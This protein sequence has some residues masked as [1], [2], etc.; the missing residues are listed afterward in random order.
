[1]QELGTWKWKEIGKCGVP[2]V[3]WAGE[4]MVEF[5]AESGLIVGIIWFKKKLVNKYTWLRNNR[6][7]QA[8]MD[9]VM[10]DKKLK[11]RLEDVNVLRS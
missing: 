7:N 11:G 2:L 8:F 6:T 9:W 5:C 1:M 3:N 10:V 4:R